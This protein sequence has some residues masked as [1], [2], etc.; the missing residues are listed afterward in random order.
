MRCITTVRDP[1]R[2]AVSLVH[3]G[4]GGTAATLSDVPKVDELLATE[5][6]F[7]GKM[8]SKPAINL[9]PPPALA[10]AGTL[11]V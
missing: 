5:V 10:A 4:A 11:H 8:L 1:S 9:P 3:D 6:A 2:D 7:V